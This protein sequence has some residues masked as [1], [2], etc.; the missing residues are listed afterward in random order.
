MS[1]LISSDVGNA[2]KI[3]GE[4]RGVLLKKYTEEEIAEICIDILNNEKKAKKIGKD[5][6]KYVEKHHSWDNISKK[7]QE[8]YKEVINEKSNPKK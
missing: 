7:T 4:D 3:L 8:L 5:A 2:K 1:Y 6:R